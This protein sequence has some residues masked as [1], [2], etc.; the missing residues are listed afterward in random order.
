MRRLFPILA[1]LTALPAGAVADGV[2]APYQMES[3][4]GDDRAGV[5][6]M[7]G[8]Y[9]LDLFA[10]IDITTVSLDA[11]VQTEVAPNVIVFGRVPFQYARLSADGA[12]DESGTSLGNVT[13]GAMFVSRSGTTTVGGG[14]SLSLPTADDDGDGGNAALFH[15]LFRVSSYGLYLPNTWTIRLH[16]DVRVEQGKTFVQA[17]GGLDYLTLDGEDEDEDLKLLRIGVAGGAMINPTVA[18]IAE[19]TTM[20]SILEDNEG[21]DDEEWVHTLDL[22]V[23]ARSGNTL[24]GAR[25]YLPLDE[26]FR[27]A[28]MMGLGVD[29]SG[30]F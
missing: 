3:L 30:V 14:G 19:L 8:R 5:D 2:T 6:I 18:L 23:R 13:G 21:E 20:S 29:V 17:R 22:G 25:I 26:D 7:L 10:E 12:D 9:E 15:S 24:F 16:G 4:D 11:F 27:D 1:T 28:N